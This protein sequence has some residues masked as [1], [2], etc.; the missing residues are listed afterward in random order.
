LFF[1]RNLENKDGVVCRDFLLDGT[2][3]YL[4]PK[5]TFTDI[6]MVGNEHQEDL[7]DG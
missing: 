1:D 5:H 7:T 6:E 3:L 2:I 4:E